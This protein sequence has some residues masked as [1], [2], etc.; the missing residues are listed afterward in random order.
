MNQPG[1]LTINFIH[2]SLLSWFKIAGR[3]FPWRETRNPYKILI[4]EKLLQQTSTRPTL[5]EAYNGLTK[6]Y[7]VVGDL[8]GADIEDILHFVQPLGFHYRA[9]EL[10]KLAKTIQD[11]HCGSIPADIDQLMKL[12]GVGDYIARAILCFGFGEDVPIVDTNVAR[13]LYRLFNFPG[14]MPANPA[15]KKSLIKLAG[16]L[17][18]KGEAR[19][20]NLAVLDLGALVCKSHRPKCFDCPLSSICKS[21]F[22]MGENN[23]RT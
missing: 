19:E 20:F 12:P 23:D 7:P 8:A 4:A 13:I 22:R 9:A 18:P 5:I 10:V 15:R 11:K 6:R 2:K 16:W 17:I 21:A 1:E 14:K 3:K